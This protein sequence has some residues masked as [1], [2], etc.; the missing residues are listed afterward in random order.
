MDASTLLG[1][2][3]DDR[4]NDHDLAILSPSGVAL[5]G[6]NP[7][8]ELT[9]SFAP[10]RSDERDPFDLS[11]LQV[12]DILVIDLQRPQDLAVQLLVHSRSV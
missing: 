4:H 1:A 9:P 5:E 10:E 6:A 3:L 7:P 12:R 2:G 11:W 8:T